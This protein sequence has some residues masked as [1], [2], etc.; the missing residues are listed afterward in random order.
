MLLLG[1]VLGVKVL[2]MD[3]ELSILISVGSVI[4]GAVAILALESALKSED[5]KSFIALAMVVLFG[6]LS[7]LVYPLLY[8]SQLLPFDTQQR[9]LFIGFALHEVANV[10]GTDVTISWESA[11]YTLIVKMI[12][13]IL[14]VPL[15]FLQSKSAYKRKLE[16][17]YFTLAFLALII[18]HFSVSL[19]QVLLNFLQVLCV[20]SLSVAMAS[21][22]LDIHFKNFANSSKN[23]LNL[24]FCFLSCSLLWAFCLFI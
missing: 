4:C 19:P 7:I 23:A 14:L 12:P 2:K 8:F 22:G 5:N 16:I 3:K 10:V 24:P 13:S 21:L 9:E 17:S 15:L 20:L 11:T 6:L 1:V 18:F